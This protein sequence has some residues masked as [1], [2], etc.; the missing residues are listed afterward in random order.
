VSLAERPNANQERMEMVQSYLEE[1]YRNNFSDWEGILFYCYSD[2]TNQNPSLKRIC[3]NS[4]INAKF[5]A[6]SAKINLRTAS[7][8]KH[9]VFESAIGEYLIL[10]VYL[11]GTDSLRAVSARVRAYTGYSGPITTFRDLK[12]GSEERTNKP[13]GD[14]GYEKRT[15]KRSGDLILWE[16]SAIAASSNNE[17]ELVSPLSEAIETLLKAF[18]ADYLSAKNLEK[19]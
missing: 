5:L 2:E 18:F 14:L 3:D 8:F 16:R 4:S 19:Q 13:S 6:A 7:D 15:N 11:N 12:E 9:V 1:R 17:H 10:T